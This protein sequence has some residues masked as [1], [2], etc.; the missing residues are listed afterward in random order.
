MVHTVHLLL[1]ICVPVF[2]ADIQET[3]LPF[4]LVDL[5]HSS[6]V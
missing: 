3:Y 2:V 4:I 5:E 1:F 6:S